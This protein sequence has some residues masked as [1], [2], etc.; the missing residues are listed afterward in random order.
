MSG[1]GLVD[2][3]GTASAGAE[4]A[5]VQPPRL[6]RRLRLRTWNG[7]S[8]RLS[9]SRVK[10]AQRAANMAVQAASSARASHQKAQPSSS[11]PLNS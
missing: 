7:L 9:A 2:G 5:G 4:R 1:Q 3:N 8:N 10:K 6:E 11:R